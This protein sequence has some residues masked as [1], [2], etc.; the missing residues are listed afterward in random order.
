MSASP[1]TITSGWASYSIVRPESET[2]ISWVAMM[3]AMSSP[4]FTTSSFMGSARFSRRDSFKSAFTKR[5]KR[6]IS[7]FTVTRRSSSAS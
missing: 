2:N 7:E 5:D 1:T 4:T 3:P 6:W